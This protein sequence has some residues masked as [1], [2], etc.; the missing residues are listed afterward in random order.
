MEN[1]GWRKH[2]SV[3][4]WITGTGKFGKN[5]VEKTQLYIPDHYGDGN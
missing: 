1:T 3:A 5:I 2:T 4:G